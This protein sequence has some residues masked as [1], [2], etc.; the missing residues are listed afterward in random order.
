MRFSRR[1]SAQLGALVLGLAAS[2]TALGP[3]APATAADPVPTPEADPFY[4][5]DGTAPLASLA[6]GT[7]LKTRTSAATLPDLPVPVSSTQLLYRTQDVKGNATTTVTTVLKP[8]T[9]GVTPLRVLAYQSFYDSL[10]TRC[11]PSYMLNGGPSNSLWGSEVK[12]IEAWLA[13]GFTLVISDFEGQDPAFATGPLYGYQTLDGIRA[14]YNSA[15][16]GIPA[17]TKLGMVGY[18]GGAIATEWATEM[19]PRYAPDVNSKL[20]GSAFGGVFVHPIH[21]L[22]YVDGS[23]S[24]AAV[25]PLALIGIAKAYGIDFQPYLSDYGK[26]VL[27]LVERDC[28]GE[29][30]I[31]GLTFAQLV[32]PEYAQPESIADLVETA[33]VLIMGQQRPT[34][35]MFIRQGSDALQEE[36][37]APSPTYGDGDG[38]MLVRDVRSLAHKYCDQGRPIDYAETP[39]GHGKEGAE[40]MVEAAPWLTARLLGLPAT[41]TCAAIGPGNSLAPT[42]VPE[43]PAPPVNPPPVNP[44]PG[45]TPPPAADPGQQSPGVTVVPAGTSGFTC[46]GRPATIVG[47]RGTDRIVGSPGDDVIVALG[48]RDTVDGRGGN[49]IVCGG[50]GADTLTGGAGQDVL[51]GNRGADR[52]MARDGERDLVLGGGA[53]RDLAFVDRNDPKATSAR[54]RY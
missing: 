13:Q 39:L 19:A 47:T 48:G 52:L 36:G 50:A 34:V 40:F 16:V 20:A 7:V 1:A 3:A 21:N 11:Q 2:L 54:R 25:M 41:N 51:L 33:N 35:P 49:D 5:Y 24:W 23:Q 22:H 32:K 10:T 46:A 12:L 45:T 43:R 26:Q 53:G 14:A 37:T 44:P 4:T 42:A 27:S 9:S 15:A 17:G 29:H 18:S 38:V 8:P 28:I 31:P 6:P 30:P